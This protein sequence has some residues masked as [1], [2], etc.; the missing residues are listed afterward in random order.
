MAAGIVVLAVDRQLA[1]RPLDGQLVGDFR[2]HRIA[3]GIAPKDEVAG[4]DVRVVDGRVVL[5][6]RI[7]A[8]L[9]APFELGPLQ[10]RLRPGIHFVIPCGLGGLHKEELVHEGIID[11]AAEAV[12]FQQLALV[13][14]FGTERLLPTT[15]REAEMHAPGA[16]GSR[17]GDIER[18]AF[19]DDLH[20][21]ERPQRGVTGGHV[22][23]EGGDVLQPHRHLRGADD[24]GVQA[25][26]HPVLL[27]SVDDEPVHPVV[28]QVPGGQVDI[29]RLAVA[30]E[31]ADVREAF[32]DLDERVG[33][34]FVA[35]LRTDD[36]HQIHLLA[37]Q[38]P[39]HDV[40][41]LLLLINFTAVGDRRAH[42]EVQRIV[43]GII[44][45]P[46]LLLKPGRVRH[47]LA[48]KAAEEFRRLRKTR[49][50]VRRAPFFRVVHRKL[51]GRRAAHA[52]AAHHDAVLI[53]GIELLR[54]LQRLQQVD[55]AG[56]F[57]RAAVTTIRMQHDGSLGLHI[58]HLL[59]ALVDEG[60]LAQRLAAAVAPDV[61]AHR[62]ADIR[63]RNHQ[64]VR[65]HAAVN[66]RAVGP[67]HEP[68]LLRPR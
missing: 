47:I 18:L 61:R 46:E 48:L 45:M 24:A 5:H 36:V 7:T 52:E 4:G 44:P 13:L 49:A 8:E 20:L 39:L 68:L 66:L 50:G 29:L 9:A 12:L 6:R 28:A 32:L 22:E 10:L 60:Q 62:R 35:R 38:R 1:L 53:D 67:H 65:L 41:G 16:V 27:Q 19:D 2:E 11:G 42:F 23:S 56:E 25:G 3:G 59:A 34:D 26:T 37:A 51:P 63:L 14:Q 64:A 31:R 58:A 30:T 57:V 40:G 54:V 43:R 33:M 21:F 55:L 17:A 15:F